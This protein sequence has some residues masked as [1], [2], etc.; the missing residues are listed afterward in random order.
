MRSDLGVGLQDWKIILGASVSR[1]GFFGSR[2]LTGY[3]WLEE[4][5]L[6]LLDHRLNHLNRGIK[7]PGL[8]SR[9]IVPRL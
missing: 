5:H 6:R 7:P 9:R 3:H 2:S 8:Q 4:D 1:R